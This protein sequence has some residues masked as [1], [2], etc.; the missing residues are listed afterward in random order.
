MG[1]VVGG[2]S[3]ETRVCQACNGGLV[4]RPS[5][6]RVS[7]AEQMKPLPFTWAKGFAL[8]SS[9]S[10]KRLLSAAGRLRGCR[11]TPLQQ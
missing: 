5:R 4:H 3:G 8:P 10:S 6:R 9:T 7:V 1:W 11:F 2:S